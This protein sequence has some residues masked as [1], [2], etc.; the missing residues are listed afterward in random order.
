VSAL[1]RFVDNM[2]LSVN[3]F[4]YTSLGVAVAVVI[5]FH[6]FIHLFIHS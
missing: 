2:R 3:L 1:L 4:D 6:S 5:Y